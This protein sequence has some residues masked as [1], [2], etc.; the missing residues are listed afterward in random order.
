MRGIFD[1]H[2]H[3][4]YSDGSVAPKDVIEIA[5]EK[6]IGV[7]I[8]DHNEIRG[9]V[10][11]FEL[12]NNINFLLGLEVGTKDGK[13][14]LFYFNNVEEIER[15]YKIE[16]E[17][18]KT[19]RMTRIDRKIDNFLDTNYNYLFTTIPHPYGPFKKNIEYKKDLSQKIINFVDTIEIYNS[20]QKQSSNKKALK[21]SKKIKK[22]QTA[23]SDAHIKEDIGKGLTYLEIENNNL[24]RTEIVKT[25]TFNF[26]S[27][28]KTLSVIG[29][30]N[31]NYS[32]LGNKYV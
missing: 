26:L 31:I 19:K 15:F 12:A 32:I 27:V 22:F 24:L 9:S 10:K 14:I 29:Y 8:T 16:I 2:I 28:F 11:G 25:E 23:S 17:P 4:K 13:E 18:F 20:T 1:L 21:L 7:A 30:F 5:K 6:K 3:T